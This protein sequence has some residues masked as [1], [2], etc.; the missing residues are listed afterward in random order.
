MILIITTVV[1]FYTVFFMSVNK[2]NRA[3]AI[4]H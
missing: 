4:Q 3:E 1:L 2:L